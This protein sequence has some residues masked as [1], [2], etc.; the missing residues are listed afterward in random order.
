MRYI[1]AGLGQLGRRA[2]AESMLPMLRKLDP[3][4]AHAE[5]YLARYYV[6]REALDHILDGLRKAG[7]D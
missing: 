4:L 7:L 6:A 5:A 1:V 2:E 3:T